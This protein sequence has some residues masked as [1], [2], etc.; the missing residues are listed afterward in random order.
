VK[1]SGWKLFSVIP[2]VDLVCDAD[3][4]T[5]EWFFYYVSRHL[6]WLMT[7]IVSEEPA[8]YSF[9]TLK[10]ETADSCETLL[11]LPVYRTVHSGCVNVPVMCT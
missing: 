6:I 8:A 4:L 5:D 11:G 7:V 3:Q 10:A 2:S 1:K 9:S